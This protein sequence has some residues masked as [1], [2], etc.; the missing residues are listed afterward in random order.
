[1]STTVSATHAWTS[2]ERCWSWCGLPSF[3]QWHTAHRTSAGQTLGKAAL[4]NP[5]NDQKR[6]TRAEPSNGLWRRFREVKGYFEQGSEDR[7][8]ADKPT[9]D[10]LLVPGLWLE[11]GLWPTLV[12][13]HTGCKQRSCSGKEEEEGQESKTDKEVEEEE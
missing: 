10:Q 2:S 3:Y 4:Q 12:P 1:M 13:Q 11:T 6:P 7:D 5:K 8:F 9:V